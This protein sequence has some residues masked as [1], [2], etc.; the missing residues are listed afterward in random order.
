[1]D[2]SENQYMTVI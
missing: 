2:S 1:M